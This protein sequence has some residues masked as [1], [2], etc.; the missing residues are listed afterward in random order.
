MLHSESEIRGCV[1]I[2]IGPH[3][4][5]AVHLQ[6]L[7][8]RNRHHTATVETVS[9][10]PFQEDAAYSGENNNFDFLNTFYRAFDMRVIKK[11]TNPYS[12]SELHRPSEISLVAIS[13]RS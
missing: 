7:R 12:L 1:K 4:H 5:V 2:T 6:T 11:K 8:L 10:H 13:V 9:S 3:T